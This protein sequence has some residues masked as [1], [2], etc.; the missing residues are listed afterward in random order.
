MRSIK[1]V[2]EVLDAPI[3][4]PTRAQPLT[5]A[6]IDS[7][8]I[9]PGQLFVALSG[10]R[11]DGHRFLEDAFRRGASGAL[12]HDVPTGD[13]AGLA[14]CIQ[15]P[16]PLNALQKLAT[17]RRA[18]LSIPV[19]GITGSAGKTTTKELIYAV[20]SERYQVYCSPG[21]FNTEIGL[22]LALLNV[23]DETDV[24]VVE[25]GLQHPGDIQELAEIGQPTHGVL[26]SI[27]D[28]H[29]GHFRDQAGLAHEKWSL[30]EAVPAWGTAVLN[31]DAPFAAEWRQHLACETWALS[32]ER[33]DVDMGIVDIDD[34]QLEGFVLTASVE[35]QAVPIETQLLGRHNGYAVLAALATGRAFEVSIE[36][37]QRAIASFSPI[38]HRMEPKRAPQHGL[39]VDDTYNAS[40]TA[41]RAALK[42]LTRLKEDIPK[43]AVLG[44]MRELGD[45]ADT[46]HASLA[47]DVN[48]LGID[49]VLTIGDFAK[50]ITDQLRRRH[51]WSADRAIHATEIED[52]ENE[53]AKR[54]RKKGALV[55]VKGSRAMELDQFV[56]RLVTPIRASD[57]MSSHDPD[58]A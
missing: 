29:I 49:T 36:A 38:A 15:V 31:V 57:P 54:T 34:T 26:T 23:P 9:Q 3:H 17:Q 5:G 11:T 7:R 28:A 35:G 6:S 40:P 41:V 51:G 45:R 21:N 46:E 20:L 8:T 48:E 47:E 19:V 14:N 32:L 27:G 42:T 55:L 1:R 10:E 18:E 37:I 2:A 43:F 58:R 24:A 22:P 52:L 12:V 30:M 56:D 53:L 50:H 33:T 13:Q 25:M 4:H 44:D 39:I 16:D